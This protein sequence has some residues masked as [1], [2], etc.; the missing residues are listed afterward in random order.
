MDSSP[1]HLSNQICFPLYSASKL[2]TKA[3]QPYIKQLGLTYPQ[4]LVLLVLWEQDGVTINQITEKLMLDTN[5]VS[6]MLKRIEKL[7]FIERNRNTKDE[8]SVIISLTE[9]GRK[10]KNSALSIPDKL[11][12]TLVPSGLSQEAL[13]QLKETLNTVVKQLIKNN[14][15]DK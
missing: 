4:Y 7:E 15:N 10:L 2:I 1:L 6:P 3:Y 9:K 12:G 5:T 8:R 13:I 14:K 11:L